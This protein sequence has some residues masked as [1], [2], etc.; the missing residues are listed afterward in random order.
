MDISPLHDALIIGAGPTGL[1]CGIELKRRGLDV[2]L[3]DKGCVVDSL[4]RYPTNLVFFT[5]P[6]GLEIGGLPM[7]CL[8]EKPVRG[9][10][11]KYYRRAAGYYKLDIRQYQKVTG[12]EGEEGDFRVDAV[13]RYGQG[14]R[15]RAR[16]VVA[17]TGFY[18][19]PVMLGVPGEDLPKVHH[20]YHEPH[21]FFDQD[22]V[23]VGGANSAVIASLDLLRAGARVTLVHRGNNL[24]DSVKYWLRPDLEN[25]IRE[26]SI[27]AHFRTRL[28]AIRERE[29]V[30]ATPEG[31]MTVRNDV[32]LAMTGY[33]PDFAFLSRLGAEMDEASG[34]PRLDPATLETGRK[35]FYLAGVV[36]AGTHTGEIFIENGR[37]HGE[38][39]AEAIASRA[40]A[41]AGATV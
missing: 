40:R 21:P 19:I 22:V 25:R 35:G 5:T 34:R 4:Y 15:H 10:A 39:I 37:H 24:D 38:T 20:Y 6:E 1:A 26:G 33:R 32:V 29:V 11:L 28:V 7:T 23:V 41:R 3:L 14:V 16:A 36:V 31:E 30:F 27:P 8:G 9:E 12:M 13:D 18:D 17:A 2:I